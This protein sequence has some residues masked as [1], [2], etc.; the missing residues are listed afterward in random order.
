MKKLN[1]IIKSL[2][3]LTTLAILI[4]ATS[5]IAQVKKGFTLR[6]QS[7]INGD[8]IVVG[9][10][11]I[12]RTATTNYNGENGNH[13]YSDNVYVD[14]DNDNSTFN[15][16]SVNI[17]NPYPNDECLSIEKVLLYWAAADKGIEYGNYETDNQPG[18][19]Y[20]QVKLMLPGQNSYSTVSADEVIFRGRDE[21]PH[22][23]NDAYICVKDITSNVIGNSNYFGKYQVAN[24]EGRQGYLISHD[25]NNTGT[26]GGWQLIIVYKSDALKRRNISFFDGYAN[27]TSTQNNFDINFSGFQTV[28]NGAV[29]SDIIIGALEGD[30]DLSGDRLQMLNSSNVFEDLDAP[31]RDANNF[32]NSRITLG[33]SSGNNNFTD[34]NPASTNTLGFDSAYFPLKNSGN[35]FLD[36]N[37]T[38]TTLRL[39]SDQEAYGLY[40]LGLSVEIYE[41][42]LDPIFYTATPNNVTPNAAP[43]TVTYNAST[44]N[45]GND[46]AT[47]LSFVT[48][49]PVGSELVQPITSLPA[50]VTYSYN[51]ST[52]ELT[53]TAADGLLDVGETLSFSFDVTVNDQ[54][55][56]LENGCS[57]TLNSQLTATYTG[58]IN[59]NTYN[60]VSSDNLDACNQGNNLLTTV[61]VNPPAPATW[62]TPEF[63]LDRIVECSD[64]DALNNAQSLVPVASCSNLTP[65]K[66]LGTFVPSGG[67]CTYTGTYTNTW[68][69]TDACG[70][71]IDNYTQIITIIDTTPPIFT[72]PVDIEIFVDN[73]CN[74]DASLSVTGDVIDE[75]DNCSTHPEATYSDS[76]SNGTC[77]GSYVITRTWSLVDD[78]GNAAADQI[79]TITVTDNSA[80]DLSSCTSVADTT[81][82]CNGTDS[83]TLASNWNTNNINELETCSQD[84]CSTNVTVTSDFDF[85]NFVSTCG[86]NG[87][88][89]VNYT[90]SDDC[91]NSSSTTAT[92][93]IEDTTAPDLSTC[94][95]TDTNV[96][97]TASD[98]QTIADQWNADNMAALQAC[99]TDSCSSA[100]TV[101]SNYDYNNLNTICG[102]CGNITVTYTVTD[103]CGNNSSVSATL[104]FGDATGPDLSAC[105]VTDQSLECDG[106]NNQT[107]ADTWNNDN[108]AALQ[109]C[110]NDISVVITSDY[111]FNNFDSSA[112]CGLGGT[113]PVTYTATDACGNETT[114][115]STLTIEDTTAPTFNEALPADITVECDAVPTAETLTAS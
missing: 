38:S 94:S 50:G 97:C 105:S 10:N 79:Q 4:F 95:I 106:T 65:I 21:N 47:N 16:S 30:R 36:N 109:A 84:N 86:S 98:N 33:A 3:A 22:F 20:N 39:T 61:T 6:Y 34:R 89:L 100:I 115:T 56:Y 8:I 71:T 26:S 9:N 87:S 51:S 99:A 82:Q 41:P 103:D 114:H 18:W 5:G 19:N 68:S 113:L 27:V 75:S 58:A 78:C 111:N 17:T 91:G 2:R 88:I 45:S 102:P 53:F 104:S 108:I 67:S 59:G 69:F 24:V 55:Y 49:V 35:H 101:T 57:I 44:T 80:P 43:Q 92:L 83:N 54:C 46:D 62:V 73:N 81:I 66:T 23:V 42:K 52:R 15:S 12:S 112:V 63:A 31:L 14:I 96:E 37:Q 74:Y 60:I 40:L 28:P 77:E 1:I 110:A 32:F 7:S 25:G 72:A 29:K 107:I 76:I 48:T 85:N 93:T 70:N 11:T 64:T 13:D 90:V